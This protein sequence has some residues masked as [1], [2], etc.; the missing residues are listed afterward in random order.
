M[1]NE[2]K[3]LYFWY[4]RKL[5]YCKILRF[6]PLVPQRSG[7]LCFKKTCVPENLPGSLLRF[8]PGEDSGV[9]VTHQHQG[10]W[11]WSLVIVTGAGPVRLLCSEQ[12]DIFLLGLGNGESHIQDGIKKQNANKWQY[13]ENE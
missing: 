10:H 2:E 7:S 1:R 8:S 11:A 3:R 12:I 9:G 4:E 13:I 6:G 5:K